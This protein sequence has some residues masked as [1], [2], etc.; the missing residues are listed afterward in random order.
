MNMAVCVQIDRNA[1]S[2]YAVFINDTQYYI[3]PAILNF[4]GDRGWKLHSAVG[5]DGNSYIFVK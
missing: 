4:I 5:A 1:E 2:K 3:P